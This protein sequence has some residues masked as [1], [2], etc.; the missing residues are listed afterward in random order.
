M[1]NSNVTHCSRYV[2]TFYENAKAITK[3]T[4]PDYIPQLAKQDPEVLAHQKPFFN[5]LKPNCTLRPNKK[6]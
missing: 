1:V 6:P 5:V 4:I 2:D 3:G